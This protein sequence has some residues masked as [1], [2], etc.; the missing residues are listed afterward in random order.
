MV[1]EERELEEISNSLQV[2]QAKGDALRQQIEAMQSSVLELSAAMEALKNLEKVK[3]DT[4][5]PL[6]AGVFISCP[7]PATEKVIMSIGASVM[8]QKKPEEAIKI[9]VERQK[10]MTDAVELA[11]EDLKGI[12]GKIEEL[13]RRA[14][15]I[16]AVMEGGSVRPSKEQAV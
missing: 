13:T 10:K 3:G 12:I 9:L 6:G 16:G 11:Q 1:G 15:I 14:S 4:L 8:V 7:K 2:Q 5:V